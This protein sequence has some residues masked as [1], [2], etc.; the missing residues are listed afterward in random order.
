MLSTPASI[1]FTGLND[2]FVP[3]F[4]AGGSP[5]FPLPYC[6]SA[7]LRV[8]SSPAATEI[9]TVRSSLRRLPST[10]S[11]ILFV[12]IVCISFARQLPASRE[13]II[14][15]FRAPRQLYPDETINYGSPNG[16]AGYGTCFQA[17][18][19]FDYQDFRLSCVA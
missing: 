12:F 15:G 19:C 5:C 11:D 2:V 4:V 17:L 9:A 18:N 13:N 1:C 8:K 7:E 16:G 3:G 6:A 14:D 10:P